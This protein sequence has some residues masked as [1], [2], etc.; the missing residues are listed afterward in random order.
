LFGGILSRMH[1]NFIPKKISEME[2]DN[3]GT[4]IQPVLHELKTLKSV[5]VIR[6]NLQ[7]CLGSNLTRI[8]RPLV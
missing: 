2:L 4:S 3:A 5:W 8:R 6:I 1:A 7:I